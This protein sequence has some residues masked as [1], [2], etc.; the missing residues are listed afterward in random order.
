MGCESWVGMVGYLEGM[1]RRSWEI[2][3]MVYL[4]MLTG[5]S[6]FGRVG[7]MKKETECCT[8]FVKIKSNESYDSRKNVIL[9]QNQKMH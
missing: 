8:K 1:I 2:Q 4:V 7:Y 9:F 6:D 3:R 5:Y